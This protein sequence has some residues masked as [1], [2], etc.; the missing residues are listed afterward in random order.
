MGKKVRIKDGAKTE[1]VYNLQVAEK[2]EYFANN[3]LVHNCMALA[4]ALQAFEQQ[5]DTIQPER[6]TIKGFWT[7]LQLEL[8]VMQGRIDSQSAMEYNE[9]RQAIENRGKIERKSKYAR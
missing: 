5:D 7:E 4:I 9:R 1:K 8:A 3:I 6:G 2:H